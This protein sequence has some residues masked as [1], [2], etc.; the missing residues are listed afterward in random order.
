MKK[1]LVILGFTAAILAA[2]L[3]V[4]S[5]SNLAILPIIIAFIS[6]LGLIYLSNKKK[7]KIKTVQ[8]IFLV[9]IMALGQCIYNGVY[10]KDETVKTDQLDKNEEDKPEKDEKLINDSTTN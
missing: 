8:Y 10:S 3:S 1:L 6:G 9:L 2:I 7:T 4:T 5:Y